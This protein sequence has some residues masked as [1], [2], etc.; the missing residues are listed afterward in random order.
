MRAFAFANAGPDELV[1]LPTVLLK[2]LYFDSR[3][4]LSRG[5]QLH[6]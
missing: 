1:S 6:K 2:M 3:D 5:F 4:E